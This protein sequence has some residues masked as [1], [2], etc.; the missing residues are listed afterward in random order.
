MSLPPVRKQSP[1]VALTKEQFRERFFAKFYDPAFAGVG[2]ELEKVFEV[3]WSGY[4]EY[5]KSPRKREAG[6][7]Y[8]D[9]KFQLPVEWLETRATIDAAQKQWSDAALPTRTRASRVRSCNHTFRVIK[10]RDFSR[11]SLR[12]SAS[13]FTS[14]LSTPAYLILYPFIFPPTN[15]KE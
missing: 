10:R 14:L 1:Y 15:F 2:A 7:G 5:R 12:V 4:I 6:A 13:G 9:P 11:A 3:A 8:A